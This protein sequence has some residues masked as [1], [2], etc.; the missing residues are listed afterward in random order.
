MGALLS[1]PG[2]RLRIRPAVLEALH[3][4]LTGTIQPSRSPTSKGTAGGRAMRAAYQGSSLPSPLDDCAFP[5]PSHTT[6][7]K[8]S[9]GGTLLFLECA[10]MSWPRLSLGGKE[11]STLSPP[12][13]LPTPPCSLWSALGPTPGGAGGWR[14]H[15]RR[16]GSCSAAVRG[17]PGRKDHRA[18]PTATFGVRVGVTQG[19]RPSPEPGRDMQGSLRGILRAAADRTPA[20]E[21][22]PD[23]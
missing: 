14:A 8:A 15:P 13:T 7:Q 4:L 16:A 19:P 11:Q 6:V 12:F 17:V 1:G 23:L 20:P 10:S 21:A 3:A 5:T 9:L 2:R 18:E 22:H